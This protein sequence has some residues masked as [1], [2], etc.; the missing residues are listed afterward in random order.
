MGPWCRYGCDMNFEDLTSD[1]AQFIEGVGVAILVLGSLLAF[2]PMGA[3]GLLAHTPDSLGRL[4]EGL[5][6]ALLLG[7]EVLIIADI[8]RTIIVD[9]SLESV[10]V[11]GLI[12]AIRILLSFS[13]EV[14]INGRGHGIARA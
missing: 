10:V 7:L 13:I 3:A 9:P 4:R 5:G 14:E 1:V 6:R 8:I 2:W 12:V 11:L